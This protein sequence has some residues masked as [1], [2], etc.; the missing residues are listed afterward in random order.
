MSWDCSEKIGQFVG[1]VGG[2]DVDQDG[3]D[4]GG[5]ELGEHPLGVVGGPDADVLA[6][7]DADGHQAARDALDLGVELPVGE[8]VAG[9]GMD[10]GFAVGVAVGLLVEDVADGEAGVDG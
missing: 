4:L 9:G 8:P 2:I 5:G 3:A 1:A 10:E 7:C 6:L